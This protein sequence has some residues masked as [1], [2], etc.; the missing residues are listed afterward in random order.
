MTGRAA[1]LPPD[2][3]RDAIIDA[4]LPLLRQHG[5][6][7]STRQIAEAADIAEGTIFRAFG[8][9]QSLIEACVTRMFAVEPTLE[10]FAALDTSTSL[11][12]RVGAALDILYERIAGVWVVMASLS[13]EQQWQGIRR[14]NPGPSGNVDVLVGGLAKVFAADGDALRCEADQAARIILTLAFANFHPRIRE[15]SALSNEE[16]VDLITHGIGAAPC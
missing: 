3:R 2:Q 12:V 6:T 7:V 8:D 16:I 14:N 13:T 15:S 5:A 1:P 4:T 11:E 9:K 10:K